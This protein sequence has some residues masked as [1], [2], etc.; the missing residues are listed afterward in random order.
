MVLFSRFQAIWGRKWD[1]NLEKASLEIA[2]EEWCQGIASIPDNSIKDALDFCRSNLEWP[3]SIAEFIRINEMGQGIPT[4]QGVMRM[5]VNRDFSHPITQQVYE[6]IGSWDFSHDTE[7]EL[8]AKVKN[9][10]NLI[11]ADRRKNGSALQ[12]TNQTADQKLIG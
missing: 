3:P 12:L 8:L 4:P 9:A 5:A 10:Y 2:I 7:K 6:M 1:L 11:L